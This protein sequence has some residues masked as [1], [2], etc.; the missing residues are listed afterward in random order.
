MQEL[1]NQNHQIPKKSTLKRNLI[2]IAIFIG[3]TISRRQ[4]G[5]SWFAI[6][7]SY[8]VWAVIIYFG[9]KFYKRSKTP[10]QTAGSPQPSQ[11]Q[12]T[13]DETQIHISNVSVV[14]P[15]AGIFVSGGAGSGKSKSI[16]E[17]I[18]YDAG[19]KGFTGVV[20]DFKFPELA[21]HVETAY[22]D[23]PN[24]TR[25]YINFSQLD[26]TNY[27]NPIAPEYMTSSFFAIEFASSIL[28]NLNPKSIKNADFWSNSAM[29]LL[30]AVFWYLREEQPECCTLPHAIS[31]LTQDDFEGLIKMLQTN[32]ECSDMVASLSTAMKSGASEQL[33]G[34]VSS[35]QTSLSKI[36]T[37]EIYFVMAQ[38][39]DFDLNLNDPDT[40]SILTIGNNPA[41][42]TS[43]GPVIGLMLTAVTKQL[44]QQNRLK[45]MILI[46]E[47]P[48]IYIPNV[49]N[50]PATARSNKV[51]TILACQDI[52]QMVDKYG[53]EKSDTILANLGN[54]FYGR[55][56]NPQTAQRVSQM[57]GKEDRLMA[58]SSFTKGNMLTGTKASSSDS[59]SWQEK[60]LVKVQHVTNL[61][62]GTFYA[63]LSEGSVKMGVEQFPLNKSFIQ[64]DLPVLRSVQRQDIMENYKRVKEEVKSLMSSQIF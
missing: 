41:L 27:F 62:T 10:V 48:T 32:Y 31:M 39:N 6:I 43:F 58:S 47:F 8:A 15:Y 23:N 13:Q 40:P 5:T 18:I 46:D 36:N 24:I 30:S 50:I 7:I 14:N 57:F 12:K 54:Q 52:T 63:V 11:S 22:K 60:D 35:L 37:P 20:Y 2:G 49:E 53:K 4:A 17:P 19:K 59:F 3:V 9:Y 44:N 56:T 21:K 55:T 64:T 34:V 45:S 16:I 38:G 1:N 61:N 28:Q 25:Y 42:A 26:T 33:A 51:A 29:M